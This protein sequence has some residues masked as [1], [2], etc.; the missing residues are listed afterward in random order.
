MLTHANFSA[1]MRIFLWGIRNYLN[2]KNLIIQDGYVTTKIT[3]SIVVN[4]ENIF[5]MY[6]AR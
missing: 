2:R 6:M 1:N 4:G 3:I 5:E